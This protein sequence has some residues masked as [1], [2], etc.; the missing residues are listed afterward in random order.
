MREYSPWVMRLSTRL[1][2][3]SSNSFGKIRRSISFLIPMDT[4][5]WRQLTS[6]R[7]LDLYQILASVIWL[8]SGLPLPFPSLM[9]Y[10]LIPLIP[11][12]F[13]TLST[14]L[15]S[16]QSIQ[17]YLRSGT[18]NSKRLYP[19]GL[20]WDTMVIQDLSKDILQHTMTCRY[21][22]FF[23]IRRFNL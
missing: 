8:F 6:S 4:P 7:V 15:I 3:Q 23:N 2:T 19:I 17:R 14:T 13:I 10:R 21:T 1:S 22:S 20:H 9:E 5:P 11:S 18:Q 12:S 16:I